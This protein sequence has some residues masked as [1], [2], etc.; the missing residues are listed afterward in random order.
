[1]AFLNKRVCVRIKPEAAT[2]LLL[3]EEASHKADV[4]LKLYSEKFQDR[5]QLIRACILIVYR[6]LIT[7]K[8]ESGRLF[9]ERSK[10]YEFETED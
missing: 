8:V 1:M 4:L 10:P 9:A 2:T 7:E 3:S 6:Q 5:S